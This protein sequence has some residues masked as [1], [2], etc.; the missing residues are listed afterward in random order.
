MIQI[1]FSGTPDYLAPELLLRKPHSAAV[2]W[3]GLGVCLYEFVTGVP[4]FSDDTP[5]KVFDNILALRLE[6]PS[7]S[8]GDLPL[9]E[10]V[11]EAIMS[12]LTLD[13]DQRA[14]I[15]GL[16]KLPFFLQESG[17]KKYLKDHTLHLI[18]LTAMQTINQ[19][20]KSIY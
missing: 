12:L 1:S 19:N 3:W 5:E 11:V 2:D 13:P 16:R 18:A 14:D 20:R 6:W 7:E 10:N 9:S 8:D 15:E 4:P 17:G